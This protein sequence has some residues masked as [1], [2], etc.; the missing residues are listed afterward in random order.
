MTI[1]IIALAT[2]PIRM[3]G[4]AVSARGRGDDR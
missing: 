2:R 3:V 1:T 4:D